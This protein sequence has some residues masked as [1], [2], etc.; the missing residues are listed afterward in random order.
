MPKLLINRAQPMLRTRLHDAG[1][2][3]GAR[4]DVHRH[5]CLPIIAL[6]LALGLGA[7]SPQDKAAPAAEPRGRTAFVAQAGA[8]PMAMSAK[9]ADSSVA[10][11]DQTLSRRYVAV[12]HELNILTAE[13]AVEAAWQS[14]NQACLAAGCEVLASVVSRDENRRPSNASLQ[15]RVPPAALDAFLAQVTALGSVGQHARSA[16]D[17]TDAVIDT[18]ARLKNMTAF[19]DRLR[20]LL[21]TPG[22]KLKDVIDVERELVRVQSE[23]DSLASRRKALAQQTDMVHVSINFQAQPSVLETG[24]WAPVRDAIAGA[25][26]G[27]ASS[28][29]KIIAL[30]VFLLPWAIAALAGFLAVRAWLRR[31]RG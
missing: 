17:Q 10:V 19:R 15:A 30:F 31:P 6:A 18:E 28:V 13:D 1:A 24:I 3:A 5:R 22:A 21:A 29:A 4:A 23:L 2:P 14:A 27:F 7:C 26:R 12:R 11:N 8:P 20:A 16:D 25:G 9:A